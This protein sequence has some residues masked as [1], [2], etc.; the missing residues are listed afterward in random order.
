[1]PLFRGQHG[2]RR[3]GEEH[4]PG[5]EAEGDRVRDEQVLVP[6]GEDARESDADQIGGDHDADAGEAVDQTA[7]ER[8]EQQ[9][10]DD[11]GEHDRGHAEPEPVSATTSRARVVNCA[12]SPT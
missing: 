12:T 5:R 7:G 9:N 6:Q 4:L 1:M 2:L 3:R 10:G 8:R 11:F